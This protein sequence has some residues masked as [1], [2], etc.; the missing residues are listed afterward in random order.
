M[1]Q[2]PTLRQLE[3]LVAIADLGSFHG[4]A[5]ACA[6]SQ[7]GLSAQ[8]RQLEALLDLRLLERDRRRVLLTPAGLEMVRR[9]R[10]VLAEARGLVETANALQRPLTGT[11]RRG[12]LPPA[13]PSPLPR[14]LSRVRRRHPELRLS[15][16]EAQTADLVA[17]LARG[18]LDVLLLALEAP[19]GDLATRALFSDPFHVALPARHPLA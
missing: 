2:T 17:A 1:V 14:A 12:V 11:L 7:P 10:A 5:R 3:Y 18:E 13:A 16:R 6:V 15:L 19:L 9:A 4:A 8:I